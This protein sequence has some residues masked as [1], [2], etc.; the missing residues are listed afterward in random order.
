MKVRAKVVRN[1]DGKIARIDYSPEFLQVNVSDFLKIDVSELD[2]GSLTPFQ[3]LVYTELLQVPV[4][5]T[6]TYKQLAQRIGKPLAA[7]AVGTAMSRNP[8]L[9]VVPCHRVVGVGS[10]GG[11]ALGLP[12]KEALLAYECEG[13]SNSF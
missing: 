5:K 9:I 4:G 11:Y 6:I 10:L 13:I 3:R 8:F 1:S 2:F 12:M 7:R